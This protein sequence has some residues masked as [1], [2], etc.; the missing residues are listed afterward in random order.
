MQS[1]CVA[2]EKMK[3]QSKKTK[4]IAIYGRMAMKNDCLRQYLGHFGRH[5]TYPNGWHIICSGRNRE[6][7]VRYS[8][9]LF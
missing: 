2:Q 6:G 7:E 4:N 5:L 1:F 8:S 3:K 9:Y